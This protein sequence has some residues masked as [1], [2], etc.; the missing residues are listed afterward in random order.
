[1]NPRH[2]H[3][4]RRPRPRSSEALYPNNEDDDRN[5]TDHGEALDERVTERRS[6]IPRRRRSSRAASLTLASG[7]DEEHQ[8]ERGAEHGRI[9][10]ATDLPH[11]AANQP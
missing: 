11:I 8:N 3:S 7:S 10:H 6:R 2:R 4:D 9:C 5:R 1:M